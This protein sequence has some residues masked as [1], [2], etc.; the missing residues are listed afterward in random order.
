MVASP[1]AKGV[2]NF[3]SVFQFAESIRFS[4]EDTWRDS[5]GATAIIIGRNLLPKLLQEICRQ[6]QNYS[7]IISP[8][9]EGKLNVSPSHG[10]DKRHLINVGYVISIGGAREHNIAKEFI[11][12]INKGRR[13]QLIT[14]LVPLSNDSFCTNARAHWG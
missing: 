8:L 2:N 6:L 1:L 5:Q 10:F 3:E 9:I 14:A 7:I 12:S 4:N 11:S 13:P